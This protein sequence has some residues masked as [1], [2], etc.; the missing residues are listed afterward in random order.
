MKTQNKHI[1]IAQLFM[2]SDAHILRGLLEAQDITVFMFDEGF[3]S[4][5]P[6]DAVAVGGIKLHVPCEE[7]EKADK[8]VNQFYENLKEEST[9]KCANCDSTKLEHD[10]WEHTKH[11]VINILTFITGTNASHGTRRFMKCLDC[12]YK[13]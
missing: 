8:I 4:L 6:A 1:Q 3:A 12:G 11:I 5:T 10:V 13:N 2:P 7:K 9:V